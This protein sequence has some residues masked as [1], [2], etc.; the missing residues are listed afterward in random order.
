[1][2]STPDHVSVAPYQLGHLASRRFG[3]PFSQDTRPT[4]VMGEFREVR[5]CARRR[6]ADAQAPATTRNAEKM[7]NR[8]TGPDATPSTRALLRHG[9]THGLSLREYFSGSRV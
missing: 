1:M 9:K 8:A 5:V 3:F 2:G 7:G 6:W 4:G